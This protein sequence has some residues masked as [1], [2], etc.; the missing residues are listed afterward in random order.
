MLR[1]H[2]GNHL[3]IG[4][5]MLLVTSGLQQFM[6]LF[7]LAW[8]ATVRMS[9]SASQGFVPASDNQNSNGAMSAPASQVDRLDLRYLSN[10]RRHERKCWCHKYN[11]C[12]RGVGHKE[13]V[14][15]AELFNSAASSS[16]LECTG[17]GDVQSLWLCLPWPCWKHII[18]PT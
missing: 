5:R 6:F 12:G 4:V 2:W 7:R 10:S 13:T 8:Y 18:S 9:V 14:R 3:L 15:V 11:R 17:R 1:K 16:S